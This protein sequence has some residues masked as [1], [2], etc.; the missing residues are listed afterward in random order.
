MSGLDRPCPKNSDRIV[1][2][3][4]VVV[5]PELD[6]TAFTHQLEVLELFAMLFRMHPVK[7]K[8][9]RDP[10]TGRQFALLTAAVEFALRN[11]I[12]FVDEVRLEV[13]DVREHAIFYISDEFRLTL[14]NKP[15]F[16]H[17]KAVCFAL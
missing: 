5:E 15:V 10:G 7:M 3:R 6:A 16:L 14:P 4:H 9:S 12:E 13:L 8:V 1:L 2:I 17:L 11:L